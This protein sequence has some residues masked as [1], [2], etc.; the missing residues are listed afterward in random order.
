MCYYRC[1]G[2]HR[3]IEDVDDADDDGYA[4]W[5]QGPTDSN[6]GETGQTGPSVSHSFKL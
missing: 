3:P 6:V 1:A 5:L 4:Y 2:H